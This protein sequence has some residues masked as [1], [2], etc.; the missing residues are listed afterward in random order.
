MQAI[1]VSSKNVFADQARAELSGFDAYHTT[2][3]MMKCEMQEQ[4]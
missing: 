3:A 1:E 2:S 4:A